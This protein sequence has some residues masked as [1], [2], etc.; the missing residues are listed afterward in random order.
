MDVHG[1]CIRIDALDGY[2]D[3][4]RSL[5]YVS[6]YTSIVGSAHKGGSGENPHYHLVI[7]TRV[8]EQ[9]FRVRM[10]KIFNLGKGNGH[11]SIKPWDGCNDAISYLFHE[12]PDAPLLIQHNVS[13]ETVSEA[14]KRNEQVQRDVAKAK[15]RASWKL[16]EH[17]YEEIKRDGIPKRSIT[18]GQYISQETHIAKVLILTALRNNKYVPNDYL[19]RAMVRRIKFRL[20]DGDVHSEEV[21][22]LA[23]AQNL[24]S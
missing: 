4:I 10:K 5:T 9:A 11:M 2:A 23:I 14:R 21:F 15:E 12:D 6:D 16:E 18:D 22:A 7:R 13:D 17:V 24:F 19:L 1:F 8:K 20:L 3:R